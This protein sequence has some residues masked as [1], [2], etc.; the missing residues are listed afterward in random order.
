MD[1]SPTSTCQQSNYN[2]RSFSKLAA[3]IR[4]HNIKPNA[5]SNVD[6]RGFLLG[7]ATKAKVVGQHRKKN[8]HN[9]ALFC[10]PPH[11]THLLQPLDVGLLDLFNTTTELEL[12]STFVTTM[13]TLDLHLSAFFQLTSKYARKPTAW[14]ISSLLFTPPALYLL[15]LASLPNLEPK[16]KEKL[17]QSYLRRHRTPSA[18]Y[19]SKRMPPLP[20][21][22]QRCRAR[23]AI[24]FFAFLMLLNR[25][26][27][28]RKSQ[29][30]KQVGYTLN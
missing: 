18:S 9:V 17:N 21:L 20:S 26:L 16:L 15:S 12:T 2:Q 8:T 4:N 7:Q 6:E 3:L 30:V 25:A 11:S 13:K 29:I 5:I 1:R 22:R 14:L 19:A 27:L 23:S 24:P 28:R 10:L